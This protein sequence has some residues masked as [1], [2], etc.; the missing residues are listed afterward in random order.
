MQQASTFRLWLRRNG[1][2]V[3]AEDQTRTRTI[4]W[5]DAFV[6]AVQ[7]RV[8]RIAI[9]ASAA[10]GKGPQIGAKSRESISDTFW[11]GGTRGE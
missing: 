1:Y 8:A 5:D 10:R 6:D 7:A 2:C 9:S 3:L 4:P 11:W